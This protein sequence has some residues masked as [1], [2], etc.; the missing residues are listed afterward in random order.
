MIHGVDTSFLAATEL[1]SHS[2]HA[3]AREL[4]QSLNQAGDRFALAPQVLAEFVH[5][6]TDPQRC[7]K[8]LTVNE[9]LDRAEQLWNAAEI[10]QLFP[11]AD[12]VSLFFRWMRG[13]RLGASGCLTRNL[14]RRVTWPGST[15]SCH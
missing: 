11:T 15:R 2:R 6:I 3:A 12:A 9:A 10:V 8:P 13:Y 14:R 7:T 5:I 4:M 1:V